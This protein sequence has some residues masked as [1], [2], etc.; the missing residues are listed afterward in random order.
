MK[1]RIQWNEIRNGE[2]YCMIA[3]QTETGFEFYE[4][5]TWET[6][7]YR[8]PATEELI[9]TAKYFAHAADGRMLHMQLHFSRYAEQTIIRMSDGATEKKAGALGGKARKHH[10]EPANCTQ[11]WGSGS[12]YLFA[13]VLLIVLGSVVEKTIN[14]IAI[15]PIVLLFGPLSICF[16]GIFQLKQDKRLSDT[17]FLQIILESLK[18]LWLF[19]K[20]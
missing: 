5:S 1:K 18:S 4:S 16:I 17:K 12:F 2:M 10:D 13:L 20:K 14:H 9:A 19:R 8:L 6:Q 3:E 7:W 11:P 15:L